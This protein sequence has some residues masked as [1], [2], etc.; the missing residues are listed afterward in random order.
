MNDQSN[1]TKTSLWEF[2][3]AIGYCALFSFNAICSAVVIALTNVSWETLDNQAK[4]LVFVA[5]GLNW[6]NV[7]LAFISKQA[8]RIKQTGE[9]FPLGSGDTTFLQKSDTTVSTHTETTKPVVPAQPT[10]P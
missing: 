10:N 2:R 7:M 4:F 8:Q 3:A 5:I 1:T 6:S 9:V